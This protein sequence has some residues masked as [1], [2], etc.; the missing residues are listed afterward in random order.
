MVPS[1]EDR[2]KVR[3]DR[4]G[5]MVMIVIFVVVVVVVLLSAWHWETLQQREANTRES[6][7]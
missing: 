4:G 7:D 3:D 6:H 1:R 5:V 2:A